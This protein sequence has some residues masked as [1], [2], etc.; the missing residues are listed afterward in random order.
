MKPLIVAFALLAGLCAPHPAH[1]QT[2]TDPAD[3]Q[4]AV[5]Q[6]LAGVAVDGKLDVAVNADGTATVTYTHPDGRQ[7]VRTVVLPE[8]RDD[9]I[10]T[11]ALLAGNLVRDQMSGF[12]EPPAAAP[13]PAT[14]APAPAREAELPPVRVVPF[15]LGIVPPASTDL[16]YGAPVAHRFGLH[17]LAGYGRGVRG[18]SLA[19]AV[20]V[21]S[22]SVEGVQVAGAVNV[23]DGPLRGMQIAGAANVATGPVRGVQMAGAANFASGDV[24]GVQAAGGVNVS[25]GRIAGAQIAGGLNVADDTSG[26][27]IAPLNI[28]RHARGLQ[29]GVVNYADADDGGLSIGVISIVRHGITEMDASAE[30]FGGLSIT[31]R[32]GRRRLYNLYGAATTLN[33][34][35]T[36]QMYGLGLG[37]RIADGAVLGAPVDVDLDLMGWSLSGGGVT[38]EDNVLGRLRLGVAVR[39]G[40]FS[41]FAG[42]AANVFVANNDERGDALRPQLD[43]S[44]QNGD[45]NT[46]LW[47]SLFAG[48]RVQ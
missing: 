47:P 46:R 48:I 40:H 44:W 35:A 34:G 21:Q 39:L 1:A 4:A 45:V 18:A 5:D 29:L 31:L 32:H 43:H 37:S 28:A 6:E 33:Q 26:A 10:E 14:P 25:S 9:A 8:R 15:A 42:A 13:P 20:D 30:S 16:A 23:V 41:V 27:Q 2:L 7:I 12:A 22:G 38:S 24:R 11:V 3:F 36:A 19:G 17:V